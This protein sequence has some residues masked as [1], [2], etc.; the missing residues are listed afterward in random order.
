MDLF[1]MHVLVH[2]NKKRIQELLKARD[3][4]IDSYCKDQGWDKNNLSVDQILEIR[5]QPEW[6][7]PKL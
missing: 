1:G 6:Q 4:F 3:T 5:E 2:G 7:N